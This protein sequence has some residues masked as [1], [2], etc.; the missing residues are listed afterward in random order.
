MVQPWFD[1]NQYGWTP[2]VVF[3]CTAV[4]LAGFAVW[5]VPRGRAKTF[6]IR[7]WL[8]LWA[9]ALLLLIAGVYAFFQAQPW[10]VWYALLLPGVVGTAV[11]GGDFFV[12]I[13]KYREVEHGG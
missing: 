7:S 5:L 13:K 9:V 8:A 2:G 6:I 3:G 10:G 12:I 11:L 4:L 1:P